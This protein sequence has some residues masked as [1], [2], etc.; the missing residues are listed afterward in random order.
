MNNKNHYKNIE[1]DHRLIKNSINELPYYDRF[2]IDTGIKKPPP[3]FTRGGIF[4]R[5]RK[6]IT[7]NNV[8]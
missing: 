7:K 3:V 2:T 8:R 5:E 4:K 1:K 6:D